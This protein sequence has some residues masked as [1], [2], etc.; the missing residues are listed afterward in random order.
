M[1]LACCH[2]AAGGRPAAAERCGRTPC[3][4]AGWLTRAALL[5]MPARPAPLPP[6]LL[7]ASCRAQAR[8]TP[9]LA[10][11]APSRAARRCVIPSPTAPQPPGPASPRPIFA[12]AAPPAPKRL[13]ACALERFKPR[14]Q[15]AAAA[16]DRPAR[17]PPSRPAPA[18]HPLRQP[19][20]HFPHHHPHPLP[21]PALAWWRRAASP[22]SLRCCFERPAP[23]PSRLD[24]DAPTRQRTIG[25][26]FQAPDA[27]APRHCC[28][29]DI[30]AEAGSSGA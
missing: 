13:A 21:H 9:A 8:P 11:P 12:T 18:N 28:E 22:G 3:Y 2:C 15:S 27:R 4:P 20:P 25:R 19:P 10:R 17:P 5:P 29:S 23:T 1:H 14:A 16:C 24:F 30:F 6:P 26:H 7:T